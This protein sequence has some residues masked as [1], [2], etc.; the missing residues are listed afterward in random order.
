MSKLIKLIMEITEEQA[1]AFAQ[2]LKRVAFQT[3]VPLLSMMMR[4]I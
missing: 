4:L 2:F 3:I 1:W